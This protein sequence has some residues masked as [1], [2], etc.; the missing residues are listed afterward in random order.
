MFSNGFNTDSNSSSSMSFPWA[1]VGAAASGIIGTVGQGFANRANWRRY[2]SDREYNE[3]IRQM[4]R[5]KQ[6]GLN[7]N[8]IYGSGGASV[9]SK[10][11]PPKGDFKD[12]DIMQGLAMY[13]QI[14]NMKEENEILKVRR[15]R[16]WYESQKANTEALD[17]ELEYGF[18]LAA[19]TK[20]PESF[21]NAYVAERRYKMNRSLQQAVFAANLQYV[22]DFQQQ[23]RLADVALKNANKSKAEQET[24]LKKLIVEITGLQAENK[25]VILFTNLLMSI[26][27]KR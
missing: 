21:T 6:A 20:D 5:L 8:L 26:F 22:I 15:D 7:P 23:Q 1:A 25:E 17:A 11:S 10:G 18:K 16:E 13:Q 3:P 19:A 2:K 14:K 24:E 4:H 12:P 27:N 9:V